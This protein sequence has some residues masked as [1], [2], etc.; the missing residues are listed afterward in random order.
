MNRHT[1]QNR[2]NGRYLR[3]KCGQN[4]NQVA[5]GLIV[6]NQL[7]TSRRFIETNAPPCV[8]AQV[9]SADAGSKSPFVH[10]TPD[11]YWEA[12]LST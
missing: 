6:W 7:S 11:S 9:L 4:Y 10:W 8:N 2:P 5:N 1:R 12:A 3:A